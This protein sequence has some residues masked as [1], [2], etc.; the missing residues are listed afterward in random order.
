MIHLDKLLVVDLESTCWRS[1]R[2]K[3]KQVPDIIQIGACLVDIKSLDLDDREGIYVRPT[4]SKVSEFC[5][6]LT[7]IQEKTLREEGVLFKDAC[8]KLR[9]DCSSHK[10]VWASWGDHDRR[11]VRNQCRDLNIPYPFSNQHLNVQILFSLK[12]GL[13]YEVS[14]GRALQIAQVSVPENLHNASIDAHWTAHLLV[15]IL[16]EEKKLNDLL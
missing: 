13:A 2:D 8:Q 4:R 5:T 10:R 11:M 6:S 14:L 3:G 9:Q 15:E 1:T 12:Y 16:R 7:G